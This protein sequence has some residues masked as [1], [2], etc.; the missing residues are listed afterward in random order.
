M[1]VDSNQIKSHLMDAPC[2]SQS[3]AGDKKKMQHFEL[4]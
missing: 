4:P 2:I 3:E 1:L